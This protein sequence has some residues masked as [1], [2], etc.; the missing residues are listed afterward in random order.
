MDAQTA[1]LEQR[2][3]GK[4]KPKERA[5]IQDALQKLFRRHAD[6]VRVDFFDAPEGTRVASRLARIEQALSPRDAFS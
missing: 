6:I 4:L 5:R 3:G 1:E 2:L